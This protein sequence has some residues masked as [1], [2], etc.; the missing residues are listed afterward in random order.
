MGHPKDSRRR[1]ARPVQ[2]SRPLWLDTFLVATGV[3][4]RRRPCARSNARVFCGCHGRRHSVVDDAVPRPVSSEPGARARAV[5][6]ST[7]ATDRLAGRPLHRTALR[8]QSAGRVAAAADRSHNRRHPLLDCLV[9]CG[10]VGRA[11]LESC[12]PRGSVEGLADSERVGGIDPRRTRKPCRFE[13]A[14]GSRCVRN[15]MDVSRS[16]GACGGADRVDGVGVS[17]GRPRSPEKVGAFVAAILL[18]TRRTPNVRT[19][20]GSLSR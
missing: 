13:S 7:G 4:S 10:G 9:H 5:S 15:G 14:T 1:D 6:R 11:D 8:V 20:N 19:T 2:G 17:T 12:F 3:V 16:L 18:L